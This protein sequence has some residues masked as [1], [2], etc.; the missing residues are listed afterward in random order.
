MNGHHAT[1]RKPAVSDFRALFKANNLG[2]IGV[3][4]GGFDCRAVAL[5]D[6]D[7]AGEH[8]GRKQH[9]DAGLYFDTR[10]VVLFLWHGKL[11]ALGLPSQ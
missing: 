11:P 3:V 1:D 8:G 9:H 6:G 7:E 5:D 4:G 10:E 2:E